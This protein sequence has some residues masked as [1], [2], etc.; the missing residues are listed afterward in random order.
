MNFLIIKC[1][2]INILREALCRRSTNIL[3]IKRYNIKAFLIRWEITELPIAEI[4][5]S[6]HQQK[7]CSKKKWVK[8][9]QNPNAKGGPLSANIDFSQ[10]IPNNEKKSLFIPSFGR[11]Y[12]DNFINLFFHR[13][14]IIKLLRNVPFKN[15]I[16]VGISGG[17]YLYPVTFA[18]SNLDQNLLQKINIWKYKNTKK[19]S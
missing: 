5:A 2:I 12:Y 17:Y 6:F 11:Q 19:M 1:I 10:P 8:Y 7:R 3:L 4:N 18:D 15:S 14:E 13:M 9:I 16:S